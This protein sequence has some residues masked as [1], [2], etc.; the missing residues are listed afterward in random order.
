[1]TLIEKG[2][3]FLFAIAVFILTSPF[4]FWNV[5]VGLYL[6][7]VFII[8]ILLTPGILNQGVQRNKILLTCFLFFIFVIS[9]V[10]NQ[11][12]KH[13]SIPFILI[14]QYILLPLK[15]RHTISINVVYFFTIP[16]FLTI[17][18]QVYLIGFEW[19]LLPTDIETSVK[20]YYSLFSI[21]YSEKSALAIDL[22]GFA[23]PSSWWDEP[24][25][26]GTLFAISALAAGH[27]QKNK[28][29]II[30]TLATVLT[31]SL[32]GLII[33]FLMLLS[34][35]KKTG[36]LMILFALVAI[37]LIIPVD[38]II[39]AIQN[40]I[41]N[42]DFMRFHDE[43]YSVYDALNLSISGILFGYG[44]LFQSK[45]IGYNIII[46]AFNAGFLPTFLML[47]AIIFISFPGSKNSVMT[48]LLL[49]LI[50]IA[51][52]FQ[53]PFVFEVWSFVLFSSIAGNKFLPWGRRL[54]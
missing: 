32:A 27:F 24:G 9:D 53:R 47:A 29:F 22:F 14:I 48:S 43:F 31:F 17:L 1:M 35:L 2:Y 8:L 3:S 23:R 26:A 16:A 12:Y 10:F 18:S 44:D 40:R 37:F 7:P 46:L 54:Y 51:S 34:P 42:G 11:S 6:Y 19:V 15:I 38:F 33:L 50:L 52:S 30:F 4:W 49:L 28:I 13:I 5:E 41:D 36:I 39:N 21:L 20:K 45:L 25:K